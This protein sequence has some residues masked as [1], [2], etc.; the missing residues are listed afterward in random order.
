MQQ[1]YQS[2]SLY[3]KLAKRHVPGSFLCYDKMEVHEEVLAWLRSFD[4]EIGTQETS[5]DR[6]YLDENTVSRLESGVLMG[7]LLKRIAYL[8]GQEDLLPALNALN[9][10][11]SSYAKV[12]NWSVLLES[13]DCLGVRTD[14]DAKEL[15]LA[16]DL[17]IISELVCILYAKETEFRSSVNGQKRFRRTKKAPDGA[18]F[19]ESIDISRPLTD[20]ETCLEFLL[21]SFCSHFKIKQKQAAGLLTEGNKYL[22]VLLTK[23]IKGDFQPVTSLYIDIKDN[24]AAL[25]RCVV[26]EAGTGSVVLVATALRPGLYSKSEDVIQA[27]AQ[28]FRAFSQ[29][30]EAKS[31]QLYPWFVGDLGGLEPALVALKGSHLT[32]VNITEMIFDITKEQITDILILNIREMM[33]NDAVYFSLIGEMILIIGN[34][35]GGKELLINTHGIDRLIEICLREG[36]F[37]IKRNPSIRLSA[38]NLLSLIWK[39]YYVEIEK[40]EDVRNAVLTVVKKGCRDK[41]KI[42]S[43]GCVVQMFCLMDFFSMVKS[44][45]AAVLFKSLQVLLIEGF[46]R[47]LP[48]ETLELNFSL[49]L[50]N[51]PSL[52]VSQ[53]I[54]SVVKQIKLNETLDFN[55][56]DFDFFISIT[57]HPRFEEEQALELIDILGKVYLS[58]LHLSKAALIPFMLIIS[59]FIDMEAI[60]EYIYRFGKLSVQLITQGDKTKRPG[61]K[62]LPRYLNQPVILGQPLSIED[63]V[64]ETTQLQTRNLVLDLLSKVIKLGNATVNMKI[65]E[66]LASNAVIVKGSR[67]E[68]PKGLIK[69]LSLICN[70]EE[71]LPIYEP[72]KLQLVWKTPDRS[73]MRPT[74]ALEDVK[75]FSH[76]P[77]IEKPQ[78]LPKIDSTTPTKSKDKMKV[79]WE[80]KLEAAKTGQAV[81]L[82]SV[83]I[84]PEEDNN[85][86]ITEEDWDLVL[87]LWDKYARLMKHLFR[88]YAGT[89]YHRD[90]HEKGGTFHQLADRKEMM[91]EGEMLSMLRALGIGPQI[92]AKGEFTAM[93]K[94]YLKKNGNKEGNYLDFEAFKDMLVKVA[95][96]CFAKA[97]FDMGHLP[98]VLSVQ[99]LINTFRTSTVRTGVETVLYDEPFLGAGDRDIIRELNRNLAEDP[100]TLLPSGYRSRIEHDVLYEYVVPAE[101]YMP[102]VYRVVLEVLDDIVSSTLQ[103]HILEPTVVVQE[104]CIA[105][106]DFKPLKHSNSFTTMSTANPRLARMPPGLKFAT[107]RLFDFYEKPLVLECAFTIDDLINAVETRSPQMLLRRRDGPTPNKLRAL[108]DAQEQ[109]S[110]LERDRSEHRRQARRQELGQVLEEMT[111]RKE[112]ERQ[113]ADEVRRKLIEIKRQ[114]EEMQAEKLRKERDERMRLLE[115]WRARKEAEESKERQEEIRRTAILAENRKERLNFL[116]QQREKVTNFAALKRSEKEARLQEEA[117]AAQEMVAYKEQAQRKAKELLEQERRKRELEGQLKG[118]FQRLYAREEV[119]RVVGDYASSLDVLY[120]HYSKVGAKDPLQSSLVLLP[121]LNRLVQDF[122]LVPSILSSPE[123]IQLFHMLTKDKTSLIGLTNREFKEVLIRIAAIGQ[124]EIAQITGIPCP[125]DLKIEFCEVEIIKGMFRWMG[126]GVDGRKTLDLLKKMTAEPT[127]HPREKR[128][129]KAKTPK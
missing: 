47:S 73:P 95:V 80:K 22:N 1:K 15:I 101:L 78:S 52:P 94:S 10:S 57:R 8:E 36:D 29:T 44:P 75:T 68:Y 56:F 125:S 83:P 70:P 21:I 35:D 16:G 69:V 39:E 118:E 26:M 107:V 115:Q 42:V 25:T 64:E 102:H 63:L 23:G 27:A 96:I 91:T 60:Q 3:W 17:T 109:L 28:F 67:G 9:S 100:N 74:L 81:I 71:I 90:I 54:D 46:H 49:S 18:V 103:I 5:T 86:E 92:L 123:V 93:F 41:S 106:E 58:Q 31:V 30:L 124:R 34:L 128:R 76:R 13:L 6:L 65:K 24:I 110:R 122:H 121:G 82:D 12:K 51:I 120:D 111:A 66:I 19:I 104:I 2:K 127:L 97:D 45:V 61:V 99:A 59:R 126:L 117:Q 72:N 11:P 4:P 79:L 43:L 77:K 116:R 129:L 33:A 119:A 87:V 89:G 114:Q 14:T 98:P 108:Q 48:R 50:E 62:Q 112:A 38:L 88:Q 105:V 55:T 37:D 85:V 32:I 84:P 7:E 53:L 40:N 20:S 113:K